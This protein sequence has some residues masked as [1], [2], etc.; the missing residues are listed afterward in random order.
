MPNETENDDALAMRELAQAQAE[1][2]ALKQRLA[3]I[4]SALEKHNA[5]QTNQSKRS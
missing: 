3:A 4:A 5:K 1:I 2:D